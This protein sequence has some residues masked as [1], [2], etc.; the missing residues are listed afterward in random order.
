MVLDIGAQ[1]KATPG[2]AVVYVATRDATVSFAAKLSASG[3]S[4]LAFHGGLSAAARTSAQKSW[5]EDKVKV[6]VATI[7]FGMGI[8]K[9][10]VRLVVHLTLPSSIEGYYQESGRAGRDGGASVAMLYY[11]QDDV[12]RQRYLL[13]AETAKRNATAE[14]KSSAVAQ[15]VRVDHRET[16]FDE[17]VQFC[18]RVECH[19]RK[20]LAYFGE[21]ISSVAVAPDKCCNVC[22]DPDR[23]TRDL[24]L[25]KQLG[26]SMGP[27]KTSPSAEDVAAAKS[28]ITA[29]GDSISESKKRSYESRFGEPLFEYDDEADRIRGEEQTAVTDAS[30]IAFNTGRNDRFAAKAVEYA[31][32]QAKLVE[33]KLIRGPAVGGAVAS[34]RTTA[35][36]VNTAKEQTVR[37]RARDAMFSSLAAAE[38]RMETNVV[39]SDSDDGATRSERRIRHQPASGA[40]KF[41]ASSSVEAAKRSPCK[42]K[43]LE[44]LT[45]TAKRLSLDSNVF[46]PLDLSNR[47]EDRLHAMSAQGKAPTRYQSY[48]TLVRAAFSAIDRA[49]SLADLSVDKLAGSV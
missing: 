44:H 39:D 9:P 15:S 34:G 45:A 4:A 40:S 46:N 5:M 36:P 16:L 20:V 38:R 47:L 29:D 28:G 49:S 30:E 35:T 2:A 7:A 12:R 33:Q 14:A 26:V 19:R 27:M 3:C 11:G 13:Q 32:K 10:N 1:L 31:V 43:L 21:N 25:A 22:M 24:K 41:A 48:V 17:M 6:I 37:K 8:D 23:V 18:E 42:Q